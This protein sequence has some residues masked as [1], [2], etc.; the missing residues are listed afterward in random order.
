M[1]SRPDNESTDARNVSADGANRLEVLPG[2]PLPQGKEGE[3]CDTVQTVY[4]A[5]PARLQI[6]MK[7]YGREHEISMLLASF[8]RVIEG[9]REVLLVTGYSGIGKSSLVREIHK[10]LV[11][12]RAHFISLKFD[13][14]VRQ[15]IPHSSL[16]QAF[17]KVFWQM[18]AESK[19]EISFWRARLLEELGSN[20][21]VIAEVIPELELIAGE[22]EPVPDLPPGEALNRF[23]LVFR[24][25]VSC[26]ATGEH[27]LVIFM[28]DMQWAD[29]PS[30]EMVQ[31]IL[32]EP[33]THHLLIIGSYRNNEVAPDHVLVKK[34]KDI[35][36]ASVSMNTITLRPMDEDHVNALISD[37]LTLP[38]YECRGLSSLCFQKTEGNPFFLKQFLHT[39]HERKLLWCDPDSGRWAWDIESI[40][41]M[42]AADNVIDLMTSKMGSL[43]PAA[44]NIIRVAACIGAQFDVKILSMACDMTFQ[45]TSRDLRDALQMGLILPMD[46]SNGCKKENGRGL[47]PWTTLR[48]LH[49]RV[50]QAAYSLIPEDLRADVHL[51]IGRRLLDAS[52]RE[53]DQSRTFEI[54]NQLN[55]GRMLIDAP[56]EK[57][58]VAELNLDAG[59]R[60]K[61]TLAHK[62]S[63][64]YIRAGMWFL[65]ED[66]WNTDYDLTCALHAERAECEYLN[67]RF[68]EAEHFLDELLRNSRTREEK[69]QVLF[70]KTTL[71]ASMGKHRSAVVEGLKGLRLVGVRLPGKPGRVR[72]CLEMARIRH[73]LRKRP[74]GKLPELPEM[75]DM[76]QLMLMDFM[77]KISDSA[78][79]TSQG[80]WMMI[81]MNMV[82]KSFRYGNCDASALA[83]VALGLIMGSRLGDY[84]TGHELGTA[85][86]SLCERY[87]NPVISGKVTEV[88]SGMINHWRMP[89]DTS[90]DSARKGMEQSLEAGDFAFAGYNAVTHLYCLS[91]RGVALSQIQ[92]KC[93]DLMELLSRIK[94]GTILNVHITRGFINNLQGIAKLPFNFGSEVFNEAQMSKVRNAQILFWYYLQK[95]QLYLFF[96]KFD[97]ARSMIG[98]ARE[99]VSGAFGLPHHPDFLLFQSLILTHDFSS[100]SFLGRMTRLRTLRQN[101]KKLKIWADNCPENWMQKYLLVCAEVERIM[102]SEDKAMDLYDKAIWHA[103]QNGFVQDEALAAEHAFRFYSANGKEKVAQTYL[104]VAWNAYTRWGATRKA[105]DLGILNPG[106][107]VKGQ[108]RNAASAEDVPA[109][110]AI[111]ANTP[112]QRF[113]MA[114]VLKSYQAIS[115]EIVFTSLLERLMQ[116][117][118]EN[119]GAQEGFLILKEG[120]AHVINAHIRT[121]GGQQ[122]TFPAFELERY[123]GLSHGIVYYVERT[124][125]SLVL[126]DA[127]KEGAFT[128]DP[129]VMEHKARSVLCIPIKRHNA[130][131]GMLYLENRDITGA[132][133]LERVEVL[134]LLTSQI[135]ISVDNAR[136][137]HDLGKS[138]ERYRTIIEDMDDAY[139][140]FDAD[141]RMS[142]FNNSLC[143]M[144]G[145]PRDELERMGTEEFFDPEN[146]ERVSKV[147][148]HI[149][150][151]GV[152]EKLFE[153]EMIA[154]GGERKHVQMSIT[155]IQ[156]KENKAVGFRCVGRDVTIKK[157]AELQMRKAKE[158]AEAA[159]RAKSDF[160]ANISHEIRTPLNAIIGFSE[161][162]ANDAAPGDRLRKIRKAAGSLLGIV[163]DILDYS[164]M[165]NGRFVLEEEEFKLHDVTGEVRNKF[166]GKAREKG[167][168][169]TVKTGTG[170]PEALVGDPSRL[171]QVLLNLVDNAIK[172]TDEGS[173]EVRV[174]VEKHFQDGIMLKFRVADTGSGIPEEK[175]P[176]LFNAFTQADGSLTRRHGGTGLGLT[177][178]RELVEMMGGSLW[179]ESTVGQ[180]STFTFTAAFK[181]SRA[182]DAPASSFPE[183]DLSGIRVLVVEDNQINQ[184]VLLEILKHFHMEPDVAENGKQ[185]LSK[186][187][188]RDYDAI[189]MDIQMPVMDGYQ[190]TKLIREDPRLSGVPIIAVTAHVMDEDRQKCMDA[191]MND[192][193]A[194]PIDTRKLMATLARWVKP[195][196]GR[197]AV[198]GVDREAT[199]VKADGGPEL[200]E[201]IPGIE[202]KEALERMLGNGNLFLEILK[203]F[204]L[205]YH[206]AGHK[207]SQA[208]E[209]GDAEGAR[210]MVHTVKGVAGNISAA[211]LHMKACDLEQCIRNN[212]SDRYIPL[213]SGFEQSLQVV[214]QSIREL[215]K[216]V[217]NAKEEPAGQDREA[218]PLMVRPMFERLA[219]LMGDNDVEAGT[220]LELI[221]QKLEDAALKARMKSIGEQLSIYDFKG[222]LKS[223]DG[224][225]SDMGAKLQG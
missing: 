70:R 62:S 224:I 141:G 225:V 1:V 127:L 167:L 161:L 82:G 68:E 175:I 60:A 180:G 134:R 95:S 103:R 5:S 11:E 76:T 184:Q 79:F 174:Q 139:V 106:M 96:G 158:E 131:M 193:L 97:E 200:P 29:M 163:N 128:C 146:L 57:I 40:Q 61:A 185:A 198:G 114:S 18:T 178:S 125:D 215:D 73:H 149:M 119:A 84:K 35:Q 17:R 179:V 171:S 89:L 135:A 159:S 33:G 10:P 130:L 25:L 102:H 67:M 122:V 136:L 78:F 209:Q 2:Q 147:F 219:G 213:F 165:E 203:G 36:D 100:I 212:E 53:Q 152:S 42:E 16:V 172:F 129:Y 110:Q 108:G 47:L 113:D 201:G 52:M 145:F 173:I 50:A 137:Y 41:R 69:A 6:P 77:L 107:E 44:Q 14:Y 221:M 13:Q 118:I 7:L 186:I 206:D 156:N 24:K 93:Q 155:L 105:R 92:D 164:E 74:A 46:E 133:T 30:L 153:C 192:Y 154:R 160:L 12:R 116:V 194:K 80:L 143:K 21:K 207:I 71:Y 204:A 49:D 75:K 32:T 104:K 187:K 220:Y 20:G 177:I 94:S 191:G 4:L 151:S 43:S 87:K 111:H 121:E 223:L 124:H 66:S 218:D 56:H 222:A 112:S 157:K 138:E 101:Q 181:R 26:L 99:H 64:D 8:E 120:D 162:A 140:E 98:K 19:E 216:S 22:Q 23:N 109:G 169:F 28:D 214:L 31:W 91:A 45:E 115:G 48:F 59:R 38:P 150:G 58:R 27:P 9:T 183:A 211:D 72:L 190:A 55:R 3:Q 65:G 205:N 132:F 217:D 170:I 142:F 202:I 51:K 15:D 189:L 63:L 37:A 39:L 81:I 144:M 148:S 210:K 195:R 34:L 86:V 166:A 85:A 126:D 168:A 208:L 196:E 88:F 176:T 90:I 197:Q 199:E 83:Y 54:V 117:V 123:E 188:A 182:A